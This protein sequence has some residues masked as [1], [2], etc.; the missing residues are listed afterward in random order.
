VYYDVEADEVIV[1]AIGIK[2]GNCVLIGGEEVDL[3]ERDA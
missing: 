3:S 1:R 2:R